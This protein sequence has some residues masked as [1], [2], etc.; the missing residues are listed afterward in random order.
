SRH[1]SLKRGWVLDL[2]KLTPGEITTAVSGVLL[3]IFSFFKWYSVDFNFGAGFS[4]SVSRNGWQSPGAIWSILAVLIGVVLAA[5]VIVEK[6]ANVDMPER[7]GSL[8]WGIVHLAGGVLAFVFIIIKL[9]NESSSLAF[10]FYVGILASAG[11]AAG[12]YLMAKES[13]ELPQ[14]LGGKGGGSTP[15]PAA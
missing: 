3:L 7:L 2:K 1:R 14:Q 12:G 6:L 10:G 8:G 4:G 13:G 15:P 9:I 5:H 11:L